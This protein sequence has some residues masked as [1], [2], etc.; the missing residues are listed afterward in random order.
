MI[1]PS[2]LELFQ[3]CRAKWQLSKSN[4]EDVLSNRQQSEYLRA[5][6]RTLYRMYAWRMSNNKPMTRHAI[7]EHW[8]Q[9]WWAGELDK[10]D[11]ENKDILNK[12]ANGWQL[13]EKYWARVYKQELDLL[14]IGV[15]FE[16]NTYI[17][18]ILFTT[19]IDVAL[20]DP[21]GKITFVEFGPAQLEWQLYTSLGTKLQV[22][23]LASSLDK[24]PVA[25][26]YID[27]TSRKTDFIEK[28]LNISDEYYQNASKLVANVTQ[29]IRSGV[30]YCTPSS[31]CTDCP[32][33]KECWF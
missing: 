17:D 27:L 13:L 32:Y 7:R 9:N 18:H 4:R 8:D 23:T 28:T 1:T 26:K 14:P 11:R 19:H 31:E 24:P 20:S 22:V 33:G 2:D 29:D 3:K 15:N 16:F 30:I 25:K 12:A 6:T 21:E 10:G 5:L